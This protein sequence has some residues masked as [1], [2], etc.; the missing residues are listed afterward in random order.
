M[1]LNLR[2]HL[3]TASLAVCCQARLLAVDPAPAN[4]AASVATVV[5]SR[6]ANYELSPGDSVAI[7]VFR[8]PD[9][10]TQQRISRDGTINFPLLGI[11][12][13]GGKNTNDAATLIAGLLSKGYLIRPQ[14][15]VSV[16]E[17]DKI[18]FTI[19]GQVNRPGAFD[20]PSDQSI[21]ILSAIALAGGFTRIA[22]E[23]NVLV[24]RITNGQEETL[25]VDAK[26]L[27][28]DRKSKRFLVRANDTISVGESI[29]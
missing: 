20:I 23:S 11:V 29:F 18:K 8:E 2:L 3:M 1:S 26:R 6:P 24:R 13:I 5:E 4:G 9:L 25:K 10:S 21:D 12:R 17:Y 14:V 19:L 27:I 15:S 16:I 22:N 28:N 7:S